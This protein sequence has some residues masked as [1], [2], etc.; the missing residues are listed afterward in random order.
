MTDRPRTLL[1]WLF[2]SDE[3]AFRFLER[4]GVVPFLTRIVEFLNRLLT[5]GRRDD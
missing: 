3:A 5:R 1:G 4:L 2:G